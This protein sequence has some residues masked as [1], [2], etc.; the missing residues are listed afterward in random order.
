[1]FDSLRTRLALS[2]T[3]PVLLFVALLGTTLLYQLER[4][5]FLNNLAA[6]LT[7][8]GAI[9]ASFMREEPQLWHNT[10]L[11]Q[12]ALEQLQTR[13]SAQIMLID[14]YGDVIAASW[15]DDANLIGYTV[16]SPVVAAALQGNAGWSL[17]STTLPPGQILDVAV[18]VMV[19]PGRVL[20]VVRLSHSLAEI[21]RR[22]A[23]LRGLL[24][25][26]LGVGATLSLI[27]GITLAQSLASPLQR[28]AQAVTRFQPNTPLE[29]VAESG[30][31][32]VRTLAA[33]FNQ[34]GARLIELENSRR[35]LLTGIIHELS[36]PLGAIKAA[37]QTIRNSPDHALALELAGGIDDQVDQM[38][39]QIED[40]VLFSELEY[41][42][43]RMVSSP[44]DLGELVETQCR[45]FL[46]QAVDRKI[47]LTCQVSTTLPLIQGDP[48]RLSQI[49]DNLIHNALKYTPAGGAVAVNAQINPA[50]P[51]QV[52][53][54]VADNGPGI[55]PLEQE[56]IFQMFYRSPSQQRRHQGMGIGL[57]LARQLAEGHGGA[58]TVASVEGAGSTFTLHL[59]I[60]PPAVGTSSHLSASV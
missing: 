36:R 41:Q 56:R 38:R 34:M 45:Q 57:A 12:F 11:A 8:Q 52:L 37:A 60:A 59:P 27:L 48:K 22:L 24:W 2:H 6:E 35:A 23:P 46:G 39:L 9:I 15:F 25:I 49:V 47:D 21:Q 44:L 17:N 40:L 51:Q 7:A 54:T 20:G 3:I 29:P 14:P 5:Y 1:M 26:T 43:L 32:E 58:L 53:V 16:D 50:D 18:P 55:A 19:A 28:L 10:G 33:A 30:P 13:L 31:T 4:N 42:G